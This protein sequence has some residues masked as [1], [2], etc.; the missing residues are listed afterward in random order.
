MNHKLLKGHTQ[1]EKKKRGG[2]HAESDVMNFIRIPTGFRV[3]TNSRTP[4]ATIYNL[5]A[6]GWRER[7]REYVK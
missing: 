5:L 6:D 7:E 2:R 1:G 3:N 4:A